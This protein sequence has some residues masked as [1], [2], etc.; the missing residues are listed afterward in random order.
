[1]FLGHASAIGLREVGQIR[2]LRESLKEVMSDGNEDGDNISVFCDYLAEMER[3]SFH[4]NMNLDL[5]NIALINPQWN[6]SSYSTSLL[7]NDL[8]THSRQ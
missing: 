7:L 2:T 4:G 8:L 3:K 1:M 6:N 5:C